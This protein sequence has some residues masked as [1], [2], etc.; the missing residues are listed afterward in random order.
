MVSIS[1]EI[2]FLKLI[3]VFGFDFIMSVFLYPID[4]C[5]ASV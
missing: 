4:E 1:F 2:K 3:D 5:P